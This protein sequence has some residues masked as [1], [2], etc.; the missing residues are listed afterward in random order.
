M[1][2][3]GQQRNPQRNLK[4]CADD[5]GKDLTNYLATDLDRIPNVTAEDDNNFE[6]VLSGIKEDK[7]D[8]DKHQ[9]V[10]EIHFTEEKVRKIDK[11]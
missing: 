11:D 1:P 10:G 4:P 7:N 2:I 9:Y 5:I 3:V 8:D 6:T